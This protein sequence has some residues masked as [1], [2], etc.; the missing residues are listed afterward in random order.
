[1]WCH[2]LLFGFPV[3]GLV[4]FWIFPLPVA[5][6]LYVA[7]SAFSV[8][9]ALVVMRALRSPVSTGAEALRGQ[10]GRVV[11]TDGDEII[12][13]VDG[14]LWRARCGEPLAPEQPVD[15]VALQGL[16][17]TVRPHSAANAWDR[18]RHWCH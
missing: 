12:V 13:Q 6:A 17:L 7:L 9:L 1:M 16:T 2:V 15:V 8:W 14:E 18:N 4:L 10:R 11:T 3:L 5:T